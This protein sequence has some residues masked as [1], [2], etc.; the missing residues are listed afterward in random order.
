MIPLSTTMPKSAIK[1]TLAEILQGIS[2]IQSKRTPPTEGGGIAE[3]IRSAS[4]MELKAKY[5]NMKISSNAIGTA[6]SNLDFAV[7]KFSN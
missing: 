4:F 5:S 6:I 2:L 3:K 7:C 1:P